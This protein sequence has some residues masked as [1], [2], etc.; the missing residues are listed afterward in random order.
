MLYSLTDE[1]RVCDNFT[2]C[3]S[4]TSS[5]VC[6]TASM[7]CDGISHCYDSHDEMYCPL[8]AEME[9]MSSI[10]F[11]C[12]YRK[13]QKLYS[14][15]HRFEKFVMWSEHPFSNV[16]AFRDILN[17]DCFIKIVASEIKYPHSMK[18]ITI[19]LNQ[20]YSRIRQFIFASLRLRYSFVR[21]L[22]VTDTAMFA[23]NIHTDSSLSS[24]DGL[25][26]LFVIKTSLKYLSKFLLRDLYFLEYAEFVSNMLLTQIDSYAFHSL[27]NLK[28]LVIT[29]SRL[30]TL[31]YKVFVNLPALL[32]LNVSN[33]TIV[34]VDT[35]IFDEL[36]NLEK[37]DISNNDF[38]LRGNI[39]LKNEK[40]SFLKCDTFHFCCYSQ[41][42]KHCL[43]NINEFVSDCDHVIRDR[44]LYF[45]VWVNVCATVLLF[46]LVIAHRIE[47]IITVSIEFDVLITS[48]FMSDLLL[49]F[50][51]VSLLAIDMDFKGKYHLYDKHW[52]DSSL[53]LLIEF[54]FI[55]S[56]IS[57]LLTIMFII[58]KDST[59]KWI[60][61][62]AKT[63]LLQS[64]AW[65]FAYIIGFFNTAIARNKQNTSSICFPE[66]FDFQNILQMD[67]FRLTLL[68]CNI[69]IVIISIIAQ[70]IRFLLGKYRKY[71]NISIKA[72]KEYII[73]NRMV[74]ANI[75]V[76][77]V[78]GLLGE[79]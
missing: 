44:V 11:S 16:L 37:L 8:V 18:S 52:R 47:K 33:N 40:L 68:Q 43:T 27:L 77:I 76:W 4:W 57:F 67:D 59:T 9:K 29:G 78:I 71:R 2:K 17:S 63:A 22:F 23:Y 39:F 45:L 15:D 14:T 72:P 70:F 73:L 41:T 26:R 1:S 5:L 48:I 46:I 3:L 12:N 35:G 61:N 21:E 28:H 38:D 79:F 60:K 49:T 62:P 56:N 36:K 65:V 30:I 75:S 55:M 64:V 54:L 7:I 34:N 20:T 19:K 31:Y 74:M 58:M 10:K 25:R 42:L 32:Y 24:F 53:C 66:Y 50:Y 6:L 51:I 13:Q 69:Y